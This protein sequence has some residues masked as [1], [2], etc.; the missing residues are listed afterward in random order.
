[1]D[2]VSADLLRTILSI[3]GGAAAGFLTSLYF[4]RKDNK[5]DIPRL[6]VEAKSPEKFPAAVF[7]VRNIGFTHAEDIVVENVRDGDVVAKLKELAPEEAKEIDTL[8]SD[9]T[10]TIKITY[11]DVWGRKYKSK[12]DIFGP[13]NLTAIDPNDPKSAV[14]FFEPFRI[15]RLDD[16]RN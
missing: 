2:L 9:E 8:D 10:E 16:H 6:A 3:I 13:A 1:M 14:E 7:S 5:K 4:W 12:W 15:E 11:F